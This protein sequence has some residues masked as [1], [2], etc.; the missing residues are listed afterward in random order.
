[1][2]TS[3]IEP[4][5]NVA[6]NALW[7]EVLVTDR[8]MLVVLGRLSINRARR[9]VL[10]KLGPMLGIETVRKVGLQ[11]LAISRARR[12]TQEMSAFDKVK[13]AELTKPEATPTG[14]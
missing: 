9:V 10:S 12:V 7:K 4:T 3:T 2:K 13:K 8:V 14:G 6:L 5:E 11:M 1:M